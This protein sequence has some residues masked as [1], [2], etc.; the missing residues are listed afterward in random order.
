[1]SLKGKTSRNWA[2]GQNI[3]DSENKIDTRGSSV[4]GLGLYTCITM[5]IIVKF[6][7]IYFGSQVSVYRTIVRLGFF[8]HVSH[9]S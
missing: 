5:T 1:M 8:Y 7:G 4:P 6:I 2:N 9:S 3:Y